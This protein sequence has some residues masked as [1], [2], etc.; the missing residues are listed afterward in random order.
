MV[1][2]IQK[3][4]PVLQGINILLGLWFIPWKSSG[5]LVG[6]WVY[7]SCDFI[8]G[9]GAGK[10]KGDGKPIKELYSLEICFLGMLMSEHTVI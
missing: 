9:N 7:S 1:E 8:G 6:L 4:G 3:N 2:E 10:P 5:L